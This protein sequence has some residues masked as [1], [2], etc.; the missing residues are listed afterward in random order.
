MSKLDCPIGALRLLP[1]QG[2]PWNEKMSHDRLAVFSDRPHQK[3]FTLLELLVSIAIIGLLAA[4]LVVAV[5]SAR[6]AARRTQ[7]A[8]NLRQAGLALNNYYAA[9]NMLPPGVVWEPP[10][11]PLGYGLLPIGVIDRVAR[12]GE[13]DDD[14]I[15]ANWAIMVL[16]HLEQAASAATFDPRRPISHD[17]NAIVRTTWLPVMACP[18]DPYSEPGNPF[19]RGLAADVHGNTYARGNYAINV[20]PDNDCMETW[21]V[22]PPCRDGFFVRGRDLLRDNDQVWG[23][24]VA[25]INRSF[26]FA[27]ITDGLSNT[28]MLDEIRAGI[29]AVDPR[30]AWALGQVGSSLIAR[31]GKLGY[32]RGPNPSGGVD[33]IIGCRALRDRVGG[34]F[35]LHSMGCEEGPADGS[36]VGCA[37]RSMHRGGVHVA[38]VDGTVHF[39]S[40][41]IDLDVWHALHT[42]NGGEAASLGSD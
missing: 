16:P 33:H 7:C 21:E 5:Q 20:G 6:G 9:H 26:N 42:R 23:T 36:N 14:T 19:H 25:G 27:A 24:G 15:Y 32:A 41:R 37:A 30:G 29:D 12:T 1:P 28:V 17:N 3:G 18:S 13:T 34:F 38:M 31:H 10:G 8:N 4:L 2:A 22:V 39:V 35:A 11:E 40:N